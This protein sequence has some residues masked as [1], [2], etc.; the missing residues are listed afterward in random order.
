[1]NLSMTIE[2]YANRKLHKRIKF[3]GLDISVENR[4]GSVRKG[5][6]PSFGPWKVTMKHDY[7]YVKGSKGLD[8]GG[9]DCFIGPNPNARKAYVVHI[10]KTPAFQKFDEDKAL[11]GFNSKAEAKKAFLAHYDNP[12]FY[13]GMDVLSMD[14]FKK[15][16]LETAQTGP[17]KIQANSGE[18]E[19]YPGGYAHMEPTPTYRPPS[20]RKSKPVPTDN[21]RE[22]D[23]EF[24]DVTRRK[25]RATKARRDSLTKQHTDANMRA[26]NNQLVSGFP[27][28]TVGG[29][30]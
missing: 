10:L 22:T 3:Q 26:I 4:A 13:G 30:G 24:G 14:D 7:G 9:V 12:K 21:P 15:K 18:P 1:M 28:G 19:V 20:L 11:L 25:E 23:D 5:T 2:L 17:K 27:S 8:G 29:F 6:D 16:V